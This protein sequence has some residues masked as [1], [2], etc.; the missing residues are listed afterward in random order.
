MPKTLMWLRFFRAVLGFHVVYSHCVGV[1]RDS[2]YW[3]PSAVVSVSV[4][5][6]THRVH[7]RTIFPLSSLWRPWKWLT[8]LE[9]AVSSS[10]DVDQDLPSFPPVGLSYHLSCYLWCVIWLYLQS[11][12][13]SCDDGSSLS[14]Q[15][16]SRMSQ[17]R[18]HSQ[19]EIWFIMWSL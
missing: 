12:P 18:D 19:T 10:V 15:C 1:G 8:S 9:F 6:I 3:C 13:F 5:P 2:V 4:P 7:I 14:L 17:P 16:G 11:F